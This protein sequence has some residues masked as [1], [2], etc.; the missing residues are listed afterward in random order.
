MNTSGEFINVYI[1]MIFHEGMN[2]LDDSPL[3]T[4][5][6]CITLCEYCLRSDNIGAT[7]HRVG[8]MGERY[9]EVGKSSDDMKSPTT[10][11]MMSHHSPDT[12]DTDDQK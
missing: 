9:S 5:V 8:S 6:D 10:P 1:I 4:N 7:H 11:L 12:T 2:N 3:L